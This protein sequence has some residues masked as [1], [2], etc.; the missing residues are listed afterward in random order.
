[1]PPSLPPYLPP[2]SLEHVFPAASFGIWVRFSAFVERSA[3]IFPRFLVLHH[4]WRRMFGD[5]LPNRT[6][7]VALTPVIFSPKNNN[8]RVYLRLSGFGLRG[9]NPAISP[10]DRNTPVMFSL[11][12]MFVPF[13]WLVNLANH[14]AGHF[15][16][17]F[18][19]CNCPVKDRS[20]PTVG[21]QT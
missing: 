20:R 16:T 3:F 5:S 8:I 6:P 4:M 12:V 15:F 13:P 17:M 2:P 10:V 14:S 9:G 7:M 11:P 1:M 19:I 18:Q 21:A